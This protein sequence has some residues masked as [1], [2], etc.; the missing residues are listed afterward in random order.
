MTDNTPTTLTCP[1]CG[2]PLEV[3]GKSALVR[4]KF[5]KN[6]AFV[7]G[8]ASAQGTPP[9]LALDEIRRLAQSG[10]VVEAIR[11]YRALYDVSLKEAKDAVDALVSGKVAAERVPSTRP[12]SA[13]DTSRVLEEVKEFLRRGEKIEAIKRYREVHD[14]SLAQA[15]E[16]IDQIE[17]GFTGIP[18]PPRPVSSGTSATY[19]PT[20]Y[21]TPSKP[22]RAGCG[23]LVVI[24]VVLLVGGI[25]G[26]VFFSPGGP[27]VDLLISNGPAM[28]IPSAAGSPDVRL[29]SITAMTRPMYWGWSHPQLA[30]LSGVPNRFPEKIISMP[31]PRTVRTYTPPAKR[32][33]SPTA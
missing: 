22:S 25:L 21:S 1:S 6:T 18:V 2:A 30:S 4:C 26:L 17:A 23:A 24:F 11:Q 16:V 10:N 32:T 5:C 20:S 19:A 14:V 8:V 33:C 15:K 27:I 3:D 9:H 12:P 7:P 28:L 29:R 31:S 13:E